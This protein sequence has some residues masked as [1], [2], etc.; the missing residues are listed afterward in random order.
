MNKICIIVFYFGDFPWFHDFFIESCLVNKSIDF[1]VLSDNFTI[2]SQRSNLLE[3]PFSIDEFNKLA[4]EKLGF[5]V[6]VKDG[7][8]IC[9]FRPAFGLIFSGHLVNYEFWGYSDT[10][11]ILG[12]LNK[13][14][15]DELLANHDFISVRKEFPSGFFAIYRNEEFVN[16][17]F[18]QS[19]SYKEQFLKDYNALFEECGG[20][21]HDVVHGTNI[22][23]T[24][25]SFDTIHHLLEQHKER[26]RC[27]YKNLSHE[28]LTGGIQ[29][30]NNKQS[31]QGEEIMMYHLCKFKKRYYFMKP[32]FKTL[33]Q[34]FYIFKH[35]IKRRS[36]L[37]YLKG[38]WYDFVCFFYINVSIFID[39]KL[40]SSAKTFNIEGTYEYMTETFNIKNTDNN[41]VMLYEGRTFPI[42]KSFLNDN[43]FYVYGIYAY[44]EISKQ[45]LLTVIFSDGN[46]MVLTK[47]ND[48]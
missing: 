47:Q 28:D 24:A 41:A 8:K 22:L 19:E 42:Y 4:T 43:L 16:N 44:L 15:T 5:E 17:L 2:S 29:M 7:L 32:K 40:K 36:V 37:N 48:F 46:K 18:S 27:F 1:L 30:I 25:C 14:L 35:S 3:H 13:F 38:R 34:D 6:S 20:Y 33:G 31:C 10:D 23:D 21:Y 9:D 26:V 45:N 11:I 39:L 12:R